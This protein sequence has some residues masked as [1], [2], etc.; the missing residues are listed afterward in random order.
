MNN[1]KDLAVAEKLIFLIWKPW[2]FFPLFHNPRLD[3]RQVDP[4]GQGAGVSAPGPRLVV[5]DV[6]Q[7]HAE[8]ACN[9]I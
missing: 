6:A 1:G 3:Q 2:H 4:H 7:P 8:L 5:K 9:S